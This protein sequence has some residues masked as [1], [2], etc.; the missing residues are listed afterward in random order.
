[1]SLT[2]KQQEDTKRELKENFEKAGLSLAQVAADL[3]TSPEYI[4]QILQLKSRRHDDT[5]ILKNYLYEKV[6]KVGKV[7]ADYT[8]LLGN[9]RNYWFLDAAYIEA[10]VIGNQ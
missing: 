3:R 10:G 1:M 5:W 4:D 6:K 2:L 7:P 9:C 8:A